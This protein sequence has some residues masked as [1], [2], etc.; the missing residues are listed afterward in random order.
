MYE[1]YRAES[2]NAVLKIYHD[3]NCPDPR[4]WDNLGTMVCFH[5]RY[6]LGD[7]HDYRGPEDFWYALAEEIVGDTSRV[8]RMT[9]EQREKVVRENAIILPLYLYD[10]SG[11]A[12]NTTGF[13]CP[14][15]SGQVGWIYVLK[16]KVRKEYGVKRITKK[17]R[18]RVI[19]VLKAEVEVYDRWLR[20]DTYG[21]ALEDTEGNMID[22]C[23]GFF[24]TAWQENGMADEIPAEYR[25][26][27]DKVA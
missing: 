10:H 13:S 24:G 3:E 6:R 25:H 21:Y 7:R 5:Q 20:G 2:K 14:W 19:S 26:L 27:L 11:L 16:E 8:E 15:D 9:P 12:M 4:E 22:S 18:D 17:V 23:W 1:V